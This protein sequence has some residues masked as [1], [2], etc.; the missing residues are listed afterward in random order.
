MKTSFSS[1][2]K[3]DASV[4]KLAQE[5]GIFSLGIT[6]QEMATRAD[7]EEQAY[8]LVREPL[9]GRVLSGP[10][11]T[12]TSK[13][14]TKEKWDRRVFVLSNYQKGDPEKKLTLLEFQRKYRQDWHNFKNLQVHKAGDTVLLYHFNPN[15][16]KVRRLVVHMEQVYDV[17]SKNHSHQG[18][19]KTKDAV[20]KKYWNVTEGEVK[21]FHKL[22]PVCMTKNLPKKLGPGCVKPIKS[23]DWRD[24]FQV[25]LID[26]KTD[27]QPLWYWVEDS[28][29]MK[30]LM[31]LK[32]HFTRLCYAVP[33]P[34]KKPEFVACELRKIFQLIGCPLIFQTDNGQEFSDMVLGTNPTHD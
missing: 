33:I 3:Q 5:H 22:C 17:I 16:K 8:G 28:P 26:Y 21:L 14:L 29:K 9:S 4:S 30:Y 25:D 18:Y 27:P 19:Q 7:F 15:K 31:V 24:R 23:F 20:D 11:K 34:A 10:N 6:P 13:S 12:G 32:D 2:S 1:P